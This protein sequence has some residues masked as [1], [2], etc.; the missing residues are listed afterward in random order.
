[1]INLGAAAANL[2]VDQVE[3]VFR[4]IVNPTAAVEHVADTMNNLTEAMNSASAAGQKLS[5]E[6]R[7]RLGWMSLRPRV[8]VGLEPAK[9]SWFNV[10]CN[11]VRDFAQSR[12]RPKFASERAD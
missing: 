10:A 8:H 5:A 1:M 11:F 9:G 2:A 4:G 3:N 12:L 7:G 6:S